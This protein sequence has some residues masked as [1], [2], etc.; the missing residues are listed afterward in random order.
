MT[1]LSVE[2]LDEPVS[3]TEI[4]DHRRLEANGKLNPRT[5]SAQ[6]QFMTPRPVAQFMASLFS[7]QDVS[8]MR[9]LDAGAGVGSLTAAF[10]KEFCSR[11]THIGQI[12][13]TAYETDRILADYLQHTFTDCE[14]VCCQVGIVLRPR[15][16]EED[17]IE[18]GARQLF[19]GT[20]PLS[21]FTHAILNPPYKK[22]H[23]DSGHRQLLRSIGVET[24]NLYTGFLAVAIK[25]LEPRGEL[26]A[27]VPRSFCNGPYYRPF[28]ELLL[29]E[30]ALK[31]IHV[32]ESR[33]HAFRDD[34]VLQE[35]IIFHAVK[36]APQGQ[37]TLSLSLDA[38]FAHMTSRVVDFTR[39]VIPGDPERFIHLAV[40]E[41]DQR[42][43]E[44]MTALPCTLKDLGI[45]ASTGPVVDFRLADYLRDDPQPGTFP[46]I[47]PIHCRNHFVKWPLP[48]CR[49]PNAI[50]DA[51][52]VQ[53]W[54]YPNGHY[55]VVRRFSSKEERRRVVATIHDPRRVPG[56]NIGFENHLNVFH[57]NRQGL[58][59]ELARGLAVY[60][61]STLYDVCL[62]QFNGHTQ[63]N[64]KDLY[65]LRYPDL[66]TLEK[67]GK[68][69]IDDAFPSQDDIDAWIEKDLP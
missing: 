33:T 19:M 42:Y 7:A 28:R 11:A 12:A 50:K 14:Q 65:N 22:I 47:Y 30:M 56:E 16:I 4:V 29:G 18:A 23:S 52:S 15:L 17:F 43:V 9:L 54:L 37:V 38:D 45:N 64:V 41:D 68:R 39:I 60:L 48:E 24:V 53:K 3:L 49:K 20:A 66:A 13:V 2:L 1:Q 55:T 61:N 5:K 25:L 31:T 8:E 67:L 59:P 63:V 57:R 36:G 62:R 35:N 69:V 26:V 46:L 40:S 58:T 10:V 34:E 6:G 51:P 21:R 27:I 32:F 44:H